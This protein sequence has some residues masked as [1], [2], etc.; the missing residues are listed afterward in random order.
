L[1]ISFIKYIFW[2]LLYRE[3][4]LNVKHELFVKNTML[5]KFQR[6]T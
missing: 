1:Y 2:Q 6:Y 3:L 5:D 4:N